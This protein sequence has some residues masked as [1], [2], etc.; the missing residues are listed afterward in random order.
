MSLSMILP[1]TVHNV[2]LSPHSCDNEI[3]IVQDIIYIMN[4]NFLPSYCAHDNFAGMTLKDI[5]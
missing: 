3:V 1:R 2:T 4:D 5:S